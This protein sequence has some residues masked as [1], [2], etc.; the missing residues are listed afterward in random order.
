M[1]AR[2]SEAKFPLLAANILDRGTGRPIAWP[3]VKPST[4]VTI[5]GIKVGLMGVSTAETLR[6]T[7]A[8]N[9]ADLDIAPLAPTIAA[10]A[11]R[12]RSQGAT[13]IVVLA[14]AGVDAMLVVTQMLLKRRF[15]CQ[16]RGKPRLQ[17][18]I[19]GLHGFQL[20]TE[21]SQRPLDLGHSRR[22]RLQTAFAHGTNCGIMGVRP[23][24]ADST[25]PRALLF[26]F[27]LSAFTRS[28]SLRSPCRSRRPSACSS[29]MA[30]DG[31][32]WS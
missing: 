1:K 28:T 5:A 20:I 3:N 10:E 15:V 8:A 9:V 16:Q 29:S 14:H 27:A 25:Q 7:T 31:P 32:L 30:A 19:F 13:V 6:V 4:I 23:D 26:G 12:L 22:R 24:Q 21:F 2:A 18:G 17:P 11:T